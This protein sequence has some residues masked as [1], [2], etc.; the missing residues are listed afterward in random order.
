MYD[1]EMFE[2]T[3]LSPFLSHYDSSIVYKEM[4]DGI[5]KNVR[6]IVIEPYQVATLNELVAKYP[7]T[8]I[9]RG[10][11]LGYPFGGQTTKMKVELA[12]FA[13]DNAIQEI[14]IG[15]NVGALLSDDIDAVKRD[16]IPVLDAVGD[17]VKIIPISWIVK[18]P[19][20]TVDKICQCYIDLGI[21]TLKTSAG[22]YFGEMKVDHIEYLHKHY[23]DK[24]DIEVAGRTRTRQKCEDMLDA[25]A[26]YFHIS[27]WRRIC[28]GKY[29]YM[30]DYFT[31]VG[32][33]GEY[34]DRFC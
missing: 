6:G 14:N 27:S 2:R 9:R 3:V 21:T 34:N 26:K 12:K 20:E 7:D 22:L 11:T 32:G 5:L 29:D 24:L 23:G 10:M 31:K 25:G 16:L 17:E 28:E 13:R 19:L 15:I 8:K 4:E 33:Y 18:L 1:K 30:Y